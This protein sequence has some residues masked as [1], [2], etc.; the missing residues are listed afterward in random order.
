MYVASFASKFHENLIERI[1]KVEFAN[2]IRQD[3]IY[4]IYGKI[5]EID[6]KA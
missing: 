3:K 5:E 6:V 2:N 1:K 4:N